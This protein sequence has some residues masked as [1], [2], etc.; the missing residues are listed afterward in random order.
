MTT[1]AALKEKESELKDREKRLADEFRACDY[2]PAGAKR[3]DEIQQ[4][5]HDITEERRTL[6]PK[7]QEAKDQR[8]QEGLEQLLKSPEYREAVGKSL[9]ALEATLGPWLSL[10]DMTVEAQR[11]A[12]AAPALPPAIVQLWVETRGWIKTLIKLEVLKAK[13][14]PAALKALVGEAK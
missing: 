9:V 8:K 6:G 2:S 5:L 11:G 10:V 7:I 4:T 13:D 3:R 12:V 1:V 14:V